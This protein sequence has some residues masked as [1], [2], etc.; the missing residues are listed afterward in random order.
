MYS[1]FATTPALL[2][3]CGMHSSLRCGMSSLFAKRAIALTEFA[4]LIMAITTME[5]MPPMWNVLLLSRVSLTRQSASY[6]DSLCSLPIGITP[7]EFPCAPSVHSSGSSRA[8][9]SSSASGTSGFTQSVFGLS[10]GT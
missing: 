2:F 6:S 7:S 1:C 4:P 10:F 3:A 9:S 5:S 8:F